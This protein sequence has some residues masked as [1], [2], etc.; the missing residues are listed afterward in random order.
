MDKIELPALFLG[1]PDKL[2][3][4][5]TDINRYKTVLLTGGRGG[6]KT[7]FIARAILYWADQ[8]NL[9][10]VCGRETQATIEDSVHGTISRLIGEFDLNYR[11]QKNYIE[12]EGNQSRF[13]FK[14]F[15]EQGRANIKGLDDVDIVWVDESEQISNDTLDI[16]VPTIRNESAIMIFSMNRKTRHDAVYK[17]FAEDPDCL[18]IHINYDENPSCPQ[19]LIDEAEKSKA[20]DIREYDHIWGGQPRDQTDDFLFNTKKLDEMLT[21]IPHGDVLK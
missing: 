8:K 5:L 12:H 7:E 21:N 6:G 1:T 19:I 17:R 13:I 10:V 14:G 18:H 9:K 4:V 15:K 11:V 20:R 3:P 2:L 16:I